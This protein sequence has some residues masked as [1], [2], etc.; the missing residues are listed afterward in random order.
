MSCLPR[1]GSGRKVMQALLSEEA[2]QAVALDQLLS[3]K[4]AAVLQLRS[5]SMQA[6]AEHPVAWEMQAAGDDPIP[7]AG[8]TL[9]QT[10]I[11]TTPSAGMR[12]FH[13]YISSQSQCRGKLPTNGRAA[14]MTLQT[15][16]AGFQSALEGV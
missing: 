11:T 4:E 8:R 7:S 3:P 15:V 13:P 2:E 12:P 9:L 16:K 14:H 5:G 10:G 1:L 6:R